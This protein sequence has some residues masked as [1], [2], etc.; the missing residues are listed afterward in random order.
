MRILVVNDDGIQDRGLWALAE[1]LEPLGEV[2]VYSPDR[3]YSGAGMSVALTPEFHLQRAGPPEGIRTSVPGY[4]ADAS[5]ANLAALGC[6]IGFDREPDVIVS[7]INPG[8]N[9]GVQGYVSSGTMGAA[10]VALDRGFTGIA[11]SHTPQSP[12]DKR[13][14]AAAVARFVAAANAHGVLKQPLLVNINTPERFAATEPVW[15]TRPARFTLFEGLRP[16][17]EPIVEGNRI[18]VRVEYGRI[19]DGPGTDDDETAALKAGAVSICVTDPFT[20]EV[21]FDGPWPA[22]ARTFSPAA[23]PVPDA[24]AP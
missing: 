2:R 8:W 4:T 19:F 7:G 14:I 24:P 12:E 18:T 21:M 3:N 16:T 17:E 15:L 6:A 23:R 10:R 1:A 11:V 13:A 20:A 22:I 9:T 5:P